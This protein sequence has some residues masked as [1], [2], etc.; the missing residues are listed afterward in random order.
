MKNILE[1]LERSCRLHPDKISFA[2]PENEITYKDL[3]SSARRLGT[4][5]AAV[6]TPGNPIPVFM[7]KGVDTI[8]VLLEGL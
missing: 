7:G 4:A 3:V 8:K 1:Y 5:L 2:D 6:Q